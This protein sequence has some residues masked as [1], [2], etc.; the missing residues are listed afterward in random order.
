MLITVDGLVISRREFGDT[1]CFVDII[2]KEYGL[3]EATAKGAK[4]LNS[5]LAQ[6]TALFAYCAFCLNK[7]ERTLRYSINSA[8]CK[9]SF[10]ALSGDLRKLAL[11]SYF[12]DVVKHT[13][14][15][16]Q[17]S[18]GVLRALLMALY[19]LCRDKYDF[20]RVKHDFET[21]LA[22]ELGFGDTAECGGNPESHLLYHLDRESFKTLE[23]YK[24]L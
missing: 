8:V 17:D 18:G 4:K 20:T 3:I 9:M 21:R 15:P 14:T 13:A 2:T 24:S 10:H 6:S 22:A 11:A 23:Y 7:N 12:A 5:P 1:S 16:E 19:D